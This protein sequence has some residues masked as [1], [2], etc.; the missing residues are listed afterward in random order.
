[1]RVDQADRD[2]FESFM[3]RHVEITEAQI[4]AM[5]R[6]LTALESRISRSLAALESEIADQRAQIQAN[7]RALLSVLDRFEGA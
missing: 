6:G 5:D 2:F 1:V 4:A 7:T 3:R